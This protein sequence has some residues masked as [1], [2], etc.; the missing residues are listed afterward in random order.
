MDE[1]SLGTIAQRLSDLELAI[2]LSLV[3]REHCLV[4]TTSEG[5][6]DLARELALVN[7]FKPSYSF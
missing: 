1:S 2:F 4:E 3:A 5:I 7:R 6:S